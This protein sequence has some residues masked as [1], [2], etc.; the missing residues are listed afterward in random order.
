MN[1]TSWL[2]W[3][4][5]ATIV[6]TTLMS[7]SQ[8]VGLTRMNIPYMLGTMFTPNRDR[9]KVI[10]ILVHIVNGWLFAL[11]YVTA[12]EVWGAASWW[13]GAL[14]GAV[15]ACFVLGVGLPALPAFHPRMASEY[16]GPTVVR[17]LEPP[18]FMALHYGVRTPLSVVLAHIVFG[19][20]LGTFYALR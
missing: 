20:I 3:G 4:F 9:A 13:L 5:G 12:F 15:H 17:Q 11:V 14:I 8:A 16:Q 18:G 2:I 19:V 1:W 10:G 6:L 7:G